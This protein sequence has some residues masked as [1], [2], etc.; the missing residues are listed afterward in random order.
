LQ[1]ILPRL[2]LNCSSPN[3]SL[4]SSI[5]GMSHQHLA[6]NR[7]CKYRLLNLKTR[8]IHHVQVAASRDTGF[9]LVGIC[10]SINM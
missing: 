1:T 9:Y 6:I 8:G 4:R 2:A 5:A 3:F 10:I 7:F